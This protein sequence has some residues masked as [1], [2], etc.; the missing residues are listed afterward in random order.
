[1]AYRNNRFKKERIRNVKKYS[2][3]SCISLKRIIE[4]ERAS[5]RET[6]RRDRKREK[7]D[8]DER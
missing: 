5:E 6:K 3:N 1:M 7:R 4:R 2:C 8:R